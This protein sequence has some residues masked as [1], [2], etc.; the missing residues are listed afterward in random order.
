MG[1]AVCGAGED[2]VDFGVP[3]HDDEGRPGRHW[4]GVFGAEGSWGE[5][6]EV[7]ERVA[8]DEV[9]GV[10]GEDDIGF[11]GRGSGERGAGG[12]GDFELARVPD[13]VGLV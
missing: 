11:G 4:E 8:G 2:V 13:W 6:V 3:V 5:D 7:A 10:G 9:G 1:V 12:D